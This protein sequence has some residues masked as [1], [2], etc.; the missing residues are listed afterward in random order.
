MSVNVDQSRENVEAGEVNCAE[1]RRIRLRG[2]A[3]FDDAPISND[4]NDIFPRRAA[5][6]INHDASPDDRRL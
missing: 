4:D 2:T 3:H 6:P 5:G 1:V